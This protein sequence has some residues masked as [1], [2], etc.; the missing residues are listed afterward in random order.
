MPRSRTDICCK[1]TSHGV[2]ARHHTRIH[3]AFPKSLKSIVISASR[4]HVAD[5][6]QSKVSTL[7]ADRLA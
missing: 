6:A 5:A 4:K 3:P 1:Q 2:H 7:Q